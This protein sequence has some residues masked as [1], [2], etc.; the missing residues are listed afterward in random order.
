LLPAC[1]Q[2][3]DPV[4]ENSVVCVL[5]TGRRCVCLLTSLFYG[6][7]AAGHAHCHIHRVL[8]SK[9]LLASSLRNLNSLIL[10]SGRNFS[11]LQRV[12]IKFVFIT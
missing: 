11:I 3:V 7:L 9:S 12:R 5:N 2:R 10:T 6:K 4:L 8:Q 1:Q